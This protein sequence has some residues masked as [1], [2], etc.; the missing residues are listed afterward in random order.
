MYKF[1][2]VGTKVVN[3]SNFV[4]ILIDY[5]VLSVTV[6]HTINN[7]ILFSVEKSVLL[8]ICS[9]HIITSIVIASL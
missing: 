8:Q 6:E 5:A 1:D 7:F 9:S 3:K 4:I 2:T